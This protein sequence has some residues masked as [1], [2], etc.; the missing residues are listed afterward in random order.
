MLER[1]ALPSATAYSNIREVKTEG[2]P[3]R[4]AMEDGR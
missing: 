3:A 2:S 1:F 4:T